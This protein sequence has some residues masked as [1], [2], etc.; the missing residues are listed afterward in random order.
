MFT[1]DILFT[2]YHATMFDA[3]IAGWIKALST[4]RWS[5]ALTFIPGHG[6]LS[7][8]TDLQAMADYLQTFD[9]EMHDS[10]PADPPPM[11]MLSPNSS[12]PSSPPKNRTELALIIRANLLARYLPFPLATRAVKL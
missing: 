2:G 1:G 5:G 7:S 3:D 4:I 9:T 8:A 6:P 11:P 12:P 10:A